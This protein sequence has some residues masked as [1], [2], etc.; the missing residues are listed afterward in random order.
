MYTKGMLDGMDLIEQL[1]YVL[2]EYQSTEFAR[3][4]QIH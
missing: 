3:T 2:K 4:H 1:P